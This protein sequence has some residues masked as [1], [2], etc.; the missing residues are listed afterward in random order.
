M[1]S[2][3]AENLKM[4][5]SDINMTAYVY[6]VI[7]CELNAEAGSA[8]HQNVSEELRGSNLLDAMQASVYLGKEEL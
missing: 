6:Y 4:Y 3:A 7:L 8:Q 5:I 2:D 1:V